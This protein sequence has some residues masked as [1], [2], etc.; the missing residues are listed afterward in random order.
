MQQRKE[1]HQ[2]KAKNL[3]LYTRSIM[4]KKPLNVN[5]RVEQ[6]G[7]L[8]EGLEGEKMEVVESMGFGHLKHLSGQAMNKELGYWLMTRVQC[9]LGI[10]KGERLVPLQ[11]DD[12]N[13]LEI[14]KICGWFSKV[15][16]GKRAYP[17]Q[18]RRITSWV[19]KWTSRS[20]G[21]ILSG[22]TW[23]VFVSNN[24][25]LWPCFGA[26]P[27]PLCGGRSQSIFYLDRLRRPPVRWGEYPRV[28]VFDKE[29]L[30]NVAEADRRNSGDFG[31]TKSVDVAYGE[32]HPWAATDIYP[33]ESLT[34]A[35]E[36]VN[37]IG[38]VIRTE[39]GVVVDIVRRL[40]GEQNVRRE[41]GGLCISADCHTTAD[42]AITTHDANAK[43]SIPITKKIQVSSS[44]LPPN[45]TITG[46]TVTPNVDGSSI[47]STTNTIHPPKRAKS[48][49]NPTPQNPSNVDA[50]PSPPITVT[51]HP[52]TRAAVARS[53]ALEH[54]DIE[55]FNFR[56]SSIKRKQNAYVFSNAS[57]R[58]CYGVL[59][60]LGYVDSQYVATTST[61]NT[62]TWYKKYDSKFDDKYE[63]NYVLPLPQ[64]L[65]LTKRTQEKHKF[66][67]KFTEK[68]DCDVHDIDKIFFP[69][70]IQEH[71]IFLFF[72][73]K[74][75]TIWVIDSLF[76]D[77]LSQH[78]DA[79]NK[80]V[81]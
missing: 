26:N 47:P 62:R 4:C 7:L 80:L 18:R 55:Q 28:K 56:W 6:F 81:T 67:T 11:V 41:D 60:R 2:V 75:Q 48:A 51:S 73:V 14:D 33:T 46:T 79:I 9:V 21:F 58:S 77:P 42:D 37:H 71:W 57:R 25:L 50:M 32:V 35:E 54:A 40:I 76:P 49:L 36:V 31:K 61:L 66:I 23:N 29:L 8:M 52:S 27:S 3:V 72:A 45:S 13:R 44:T 68:I 12:S 20:I 53:F 64:H 1:G 30:K 78:Q 10:P 65:L 38:V 5:C 22:A 17:L 15:E 63:D 39:V 59:S 34:F 16:Y 43:S 19:K 69:V 70:V 24:Q 74:E